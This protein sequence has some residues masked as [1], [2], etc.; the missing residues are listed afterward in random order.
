MANTRAL[1]L[2]MM[3]LLIEVLQYHFF[4]KFNSPLDGCCLL[5]TVQIQSVDNMTD[6]CPFQ[7][8]IAPT[9]GQGSVLG[10]HNET[11]SAWLYTGALD[12]RWPLSKLQ[13]EPWMW[14]GLI[15]E[16]CRCQG[17]VMTLW[18]FS[19]ADICA[20]LW[21]LTSDGDISESASATGVLGGI[22]LERDA[23]DAW[24]SLFIIHISL[25]VTRGG[26]HTAGKQLVPQSSL[27]VSVVPPHP[28]EH[29][30]RRPG[31]ARQGTC[32]CHLTG[33]K[34]VEMKGS[35]RFCQSTS[36][37]LSITA[38]TSG[39]VCASV[40]A[41]VSIKQ[42]WVRVCARMCILSHWPTGSVCVCICSI[43]N[44]GCVRPCVYIS[45]FIP[46]S[47][48]VRKHIDLEGVCMSVCD[49]LYQCSDLYKKLQ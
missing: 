9:V 13:T 29:A 8:W 4:K 23:A 6:K 2:M 48:C 43:I 16:K 5:T 3:R 21:A 41:C 18:I 1:C 10:A 19:S 39:G 42:Q 20:L 33:E 14:A 25:S 22:H 49:C 32:G 40:R 24:Y 11:F 17:S 36:G 12:E 35:S 27:V 34:Q 26:V 31:L 47:E 28:T 38:P 46:A 37:L 15:S 44:A 7:R 45:A 30:R